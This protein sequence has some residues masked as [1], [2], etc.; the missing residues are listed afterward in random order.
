MISIEKENSYNFTEHIYFLR[1]DLILISSDL[2]Y[3]KRFILNI[4]NQW[5]LLV[6]LNK[7]FY[8][9]SKNQ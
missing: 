8:S 2:H 6:K 4:Q 1:I 3:L 7:I 9:L 5:N